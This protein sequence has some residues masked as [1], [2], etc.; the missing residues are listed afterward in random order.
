MLVNEDFDF[1]VA[2][3]LEGI[4]AGIAAGQR[5]ASNEQKVAALEIV[6]PSE[7]TLAKLEELRTHGAHGFFLLWGREKAVLK[8]VVDERASCG[9][10]AKASPSETHLA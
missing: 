10:T 9:P 4:G 6:Q 5:I 2:M 3:G 7:D 8:L 1:G